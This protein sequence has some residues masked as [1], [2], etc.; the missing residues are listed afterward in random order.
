M[1]ISTFLQSLGD[2]HLITASA[3]RVK[4]IITN[5]LVYYL[6]ISCLC[7]LALIQEEIAIDSKDDNKRCQLL[8]EALKLHMG[9]LELTV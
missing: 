4:G 9:S 2:D 7:C 3:R 1:S 6:F 5:T 8:E